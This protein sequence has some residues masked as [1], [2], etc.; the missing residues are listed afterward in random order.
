MYKFVN[1]EKKIF[2][3]IVLMAALLLGFLVYES[4]VLGKKEQEIRANHIAQMEANLRSK[5]A[6]AIAEKKEMTLTLAIASAQSVVVNT[7]AGTINSDESI[8]KLNTIF[9][10]LADQSLFSRSRFQII[11]GTGSS[12]YR[13]WSERKGDNLLLS[14]KWLKQI[15]IS[16]QIMEMMDVGENS[17][18]FKVIVP[19]IYGN[20]AIGV[21]EVITSFDSIVEDLT[22]DDEELVVAI[23]KDFKNSLLHPFSKEFVNGYN[24]V[25]ADALS[26]AILRKLRGK[27]GI[28]VLIDPVAYQDIDGTRVDLGGHIKSGIKTPY[29]LIDDYYV[30][31]GKIKA[32]NHTDIGYLLFFKKQK[33]LENDAL[34]ELKHT[35]QIISFALPVL[36]FIFMLAFIF[37]YLYM[38][39]LRDTRV[40]DGLTGLY[41][42]I[43]LLE[44][45]HD[46][47]DDRSLIIVNINNF[48]N[49]NIVY[50]F[51]MGDQILYSVAQ[52]LKT[53]CQCDDV[54]RVD[55]DEFAL[56][57]NENIDAVKMIKAIQ[58]HFFT[59]PFRFGTFSMNISLSY[60]A[61]HNSR[62]LFH[63]AAFALRQAKNLGPNRYH[64][65][66]SD[67]DKLDHAER[68][69]FLRMSG[70]L[71]D[72]LEKDLV[73]PYYQGI[74]DNRNETIDK[75]ETLARIQLDNEVLSPIKF[76]EVAQTTGMITGIT[77][78]MINKTFVYMQTKPYSFSINITEEDLNQ[79]YLPK[80]LEQKLSEYQIEPAR[81]TLEI[82]EGVSSGGQKSHMKQLKIFKNMGLQLA[83]D[84]FGAEYSNFERV[85]EIDVDY[86]KI[87]AKYIKDIDVNQKSYEITKSIASFAK[88]TKILCIAEFVASEKIQAIIDELGIEY[89]QG[90]HFS[91]PKEFIE[92]K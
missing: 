46:N 89:S 76:I 57:Y 60:G 77:K 70:V 31:M 90:Y 25:N 71:H 62:H 11:D 66:N 84:D 34:I 32:W 28:D 18:T 59:H 42:K 10:T 68:E 35:I 79:N 88:N 40:Y 73:I 21:I 26:P 81:I 56:L 8:V 91:V 22:T 86:L 49:I 30:I 39:K 17:L 23:D 13:S 36:A 48:T 37:R 82:L 41:N 50:G 14:E 19:I 43:R 80:Y 83:I 20:N 12:L 27:K 52:R 2:Y 74:H 78:S 44:V 85:L 92:E 3:F 38:K 53:V 33:S 47:R 24:I 5:M 29:L 54:F 55:A 75:F 63:H 72:A 45:I 16:R 1:I 7:P 65:Y 69:E 61:A 4:I 64:V 6:D 87:D 67:T 58:A 51:E 15:L 9:K